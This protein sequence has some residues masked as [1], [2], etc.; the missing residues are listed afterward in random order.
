MSNRGQSGTGRSQGSAY[1][2]ERSSPVLATLAGAQR[3]YR[4]RRQ[5]WFRPSS[6][7]GLGACP[8]L[9]IIGDARKSATQL[10]RG[11][12]LAAFVK[13]CADGGSVALG[14]GEHAREVRWRRVV[15]KRPVVQA[16]LMFLRGIFLARRFLPT[17]RRERAL[18]A[19][20]ED[21]RVGIA[22]IADVLRTFSA[23]EDKRMHLTLKAARERR[24][25]VG[26]VGTHIDRAVARSKGTAEALDRVTEAL[27]QLAASLRD[28]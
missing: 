27:E 13:G 2:P 1:G 12:Q 22:A 8:R 16:C 10:D 6:C 21:T 11:R 14:Y 3:R 28:V 26:V 25:E 24:S 20:L 5:H 9:R 23:L 15:N 4:A 19:K 18:A 17:T 7:D